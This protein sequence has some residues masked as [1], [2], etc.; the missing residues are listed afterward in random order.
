MTKQKTWLNS[1]FL[2]KNGFKMKKV[3]FLTLVLVLFTCTTSKADTVT[4][5]TIYGNSPQTWSMP[6]YY[7]PNS[8]V[9]GYAVVSFARQAGFVAGMNEV[10]VSNVPDEID[11]STIM[12]KNLGKSLQIVEQNYISSKLTQGDL[13][14]KNIGRE[15]EV[16]KYTG[17]G[18][19][20]IKGILLD[21]SS[22]LIIKDGEK[23]RLV[24]D[25][26]SV[27][28]PDENNSSAGNSIKW[29]ISSTS[30]SDAIFEYSYR[31]SG[32]TW[33]TSY[34]VYLDGKGTEVMARIEGW[35]NLLNSTTAN[36]KDTN[37]K[38]IA[39]DVAQE[40][41]GRGYG[42]AVPM[43]AKAS[44]DMAVAESAPNMQQEKFSD[45]HMYTIDR[46]V[47]LPSSSSKKVKLFA[48]KEGILAK[49]KYIYDVAQSGDNSVKSVVTFT[50][51]EK[52]R[53]G[54]PLPGGKY[55]VFEKDTSG[56]FEQVGEAT[57]QH[58]A[59]GEKVELT[60]GNAFD[61]KANRTQVDT[62]QD[63]LRH[64]GKYQVD[65]EIESALED[66]VDVIVKE[67]IYQQNWQIV[68]ANYSYKKINA[69]LVEF[70]VHAKPKA[71]TKLQFMVQ[72]SW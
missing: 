47:S 67:P 3:S 53:L 42:G 14:K 26:S 72:Y 38:L 62:E 36:I 65:V 30:A 17:D 31:S 32:I 66:E 54:I 35:A 10:T 16:E 50:N 28:V 41:G 11:P 7:M 55:R 25:Y 68:D 8:N 15:I 43:M 58:K 33:S 5:L 70:T 40:G 13:I 21:S 6:Y 69:N 34:N 60:I 23:L 1:E 52:S 56:A 49:R 9:P 27:I 19:V 57:Q 24:S 64:R 29:L 20:T 39:G 46:K 22:G 4:N 71:K 12:V 44:M 59:E 48:D 61:L 18:V 63:Q 51:D 2:N 37:L 45:Y